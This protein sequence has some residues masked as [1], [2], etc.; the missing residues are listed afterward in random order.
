[1]NRREF[2]QSVRKAAWMRAAGTCECGCGQP[3]D[4]D[5]PKGCPEYHHRIEAVLGGSNDLENCM[6]IRRDCH[7]AITAKDSAPKAAKVRREDK[8]RLGLQAHK[9]SIPG[10][11]ESKW[12]R[13]IDGTVVRRGE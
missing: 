11:R 12:K 3:F 1:M 4:L 10:S 9:A 6:C 13:R 7:A 2:P 5:H 8:R